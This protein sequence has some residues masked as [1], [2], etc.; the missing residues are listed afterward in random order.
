MEDSIKELYDLAKVTE[1]TISEEAV[2]QTPPDSQP[3]KE[4][5]EAAPSQEGDRQPEEEKAETPDEEKEQPQDKG[6]RFDQ[7]PRWK[8]MREE[9]ETL[10]QFREDAE[11]RLREID[12]WR[13][14]QAQPKEAE[15]PQEFKTLYGEDPETFKQWNALNER[16]VAELVE[17]KL[18]ERETR[19]REQQ[20]KAEAAKTEF[21]TWAEK[22]FTDIS[23][24]TGI[25]LTDKNSNERNQILDI[26]EKY[27]VF[28]NKGRHDL[29]KANELRKE[30]YKTDNSA[31]E[32][33]KAVAAKASI[34][35][36]AAPKDSEPLTSS[37]LKKM[38]IEDYFT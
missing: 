36:N 26:C 12:D 22:E 18:T 28:D 15:I 37:K 4:E 21:V 34:R 10:K 32:E 14:S 13:A 1:E 19:Q 24:E 6:L 11:R 29:R 7:H 31:V 5:E 16:Q 33:K 2:E 8:R 23:E 30:L 35:T 25:D 17:R 38:R 3:E 20:L 9:N 27:G